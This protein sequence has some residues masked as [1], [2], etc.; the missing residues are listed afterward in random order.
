MTRRRPPCPFVIDT[1]RQVRALRAPV[2]QEIVDA[3]QAEGPCSVAQLG[4]RLGRAA[5]SLYYHIRALTRLGLLIE[6]D[7]PGP[8][9]RAAMVDV[10]GRPMRIRYRPGDPAQ[11]SALQELA[12]AMLRLAARDFRAGLAS[13]AAVPDGPRRNLWAARVNGRLSPARVARLTALLREAASIIALASR[14]DGG[15]GRPLIALTFVLTP[16]APRTRPK[17]GRAARTKGVKP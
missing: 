6:R 14:R 11:A 7:S 9:R 4:A 16:V 2:R 17:R 1:A 10:P 13:P 5:D 12:G 3:V 15:D 8:G